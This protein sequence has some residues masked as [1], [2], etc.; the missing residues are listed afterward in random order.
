ML[1]RGRLEHVALHSVKGAD[2]VR[3]SSYFST[4]ERGKH[5][6]LAVIKEAFDTPM[7]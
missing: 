6:L 1:E 4:E 2:A 3:V 5:A 7:Q